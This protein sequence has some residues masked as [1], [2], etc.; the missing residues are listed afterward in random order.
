MRDNRNLSRCLTATIGSFA[1]LLSA[2]GGDEEAATTSA[3]RPD[4]VQATASEPANGSAELEAAARPVDSETLPYADV[5]DRLVYGHFAFPSDMIE[6]LPAVIV[7]HDW[8]GLNEDT[9]TAANQLASYGYMVLAIDLYGGDTI[10]EIDAARR[11]M[12]PVI[13]NPQHVETTSGR[14]CSSWKNSPAHRRLR[15]WAGDSA[16]A[17]R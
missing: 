13:E 11:R 12:I 17:G 10:D 3:P 14:R 6:P 15:F 1:L 5:D 7:V 9:R 8:W 4:P 16:G 2:C